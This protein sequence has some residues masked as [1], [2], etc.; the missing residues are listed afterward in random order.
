MEMEGRL[1]FSMGEGEGRGLHGEFWVGICRILYLEKMGAVLLY[2][3]VNF[4][5]FS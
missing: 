2:S 1:V 3:T 5:L 4:G